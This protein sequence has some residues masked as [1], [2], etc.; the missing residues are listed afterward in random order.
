M[1]CGPK[2]M[3]EAILR[4]LK[5]KTGKSLEEWISVV[6]K[7]GLSEKKST[8]AFLKK[9][10]GLGHFQAQKVFEVFADIKPYENTA[11]FAETLFDRPILKELYQNIRQQL[12]SLG[13]DVKEQPC[14]TYIPFYR[15]NQFA[16]LQPKGDQQITIGLN[17]PTS[18]SVS[19]FEQKNV[20]GSERINHYKI[21]SEKEVLDTSTLAA[22]KI[23][24][25]N[26]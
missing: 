8:M 9:E 7:S 17:L 1:A 20:A 4:N 6:D 10:H 26:N 12:L 18:A 13:D 2:Q 11:A 22:I 16:L 25:Q 14:K 19:G 24:Y 3:G 15:K 5:S 21:I 23:A